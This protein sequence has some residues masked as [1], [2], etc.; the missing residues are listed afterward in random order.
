MTETHATNHKVFS[1]KWKLPT[2]EYVSEP[3][4]CLTA[5][6][7]MEAIIMEHKHLPEM[8]SAKEGELEGMDIAAMN[9][10]LMK[11]AEHMQLYILQQKKTI[12][13]METR[14]AVR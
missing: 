3:D 14:K 11:Q 8:L 7:E 2:P 4:H 9:L 10:R 13:A 5:F 1:E 6:S 12:K